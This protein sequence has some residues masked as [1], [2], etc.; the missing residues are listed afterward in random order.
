MVR[1]YPILRLDFLSR[2]NPIRV[3]FSS[4]FDLCAVASNSSPAL[5]SFLIPS[6]V[7]VARLA[8]HHHQSVR[9]V[10]LST[11]TT[12]TFVNLGASS[13]SLLSLAVRKE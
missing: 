1:I 2:P 4:I 3:V 5:S 13:L 8:W 7:A 9:R 6:L 11:T 12:M 10:I